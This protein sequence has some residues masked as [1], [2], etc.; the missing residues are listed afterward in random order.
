MSRKFICEGLLYISQLTLHEK[1]KTRFPAFFL[2]YLI[3]FSNIK[4]SNQ[5]K[6][7]L[8]RAYSTISRGTPDDVLRK[9]GWEALDTGMV[10]PV[11]L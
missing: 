1:K 2:Y 10:T 4:I 3:F 9:P 6:V 11:C 7:Y 5:S 8:N